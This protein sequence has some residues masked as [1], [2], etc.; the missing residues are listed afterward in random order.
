[1]RL[2]ILV[3]AICLPV[4]SVACVL[5]QAPA[6][7]PCSLLKGYY[8]CD[9]AAFAMYLKEPRTVAVESQPSNLATNKALRDLVRS[10]GETET[11][12][13]VDLT[14]V[15]V[16]APDA[17]VYFGPNDRELA[18]LRIY[19]RVRQDARGQLIWVET[20]T[21]QPDTPW[22]TAVYN[23]IQQFKASMK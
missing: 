10:L 6:P 22:P 14:F 8:H 21:G 17:G 13:N 1:M 2:R 16:K 18:S 19:S 15:L 5:A 23:L 9:Q 11:A 4:S 12:E 20:L 7:P 3:A